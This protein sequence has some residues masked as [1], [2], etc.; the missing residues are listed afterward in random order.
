MIPRV[1]HFVWIGDDIRRPDNC[2]DTWRALNPDIPIRLWTNADLSDSWE[3]RYHMEAFITKK[4]YKGAV[5]LMRLEIMHR[6]GGIVLDADTFCLRSLDSFFFEG[7]LFSCWENEFVRHGFI[8]AG[9]LG[10]RPGHPFFES[11]ILL[12]QQKESL[13]YD[14]AW[15]TSGTLPLSIHYWNYRPADMTIFPSQYFLPYHYTGQRYY[16]SGPVYGHQ[17]WTDTLKI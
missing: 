7:D 9:C 14:V 10:S 3:N 5:N 8:S 17:L 16:G 11:L 1:L 15:K 13:T 4:E 6:V 2:L 12:L